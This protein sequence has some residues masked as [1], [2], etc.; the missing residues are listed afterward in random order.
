MFAGVFSLSMKGQIMD[1][2]TDILL[3]D[4]RH[5]IAD[6]GKGGGM[7]SPSIYDTAQVLRMAPPGRGCLAGHK[8]AVGT[9]TA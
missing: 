7:I 3:T 4:L 2:I 5:L 9:A 8:L 6:L 1:R